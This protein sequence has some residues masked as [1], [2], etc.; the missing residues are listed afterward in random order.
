MFLASVACIFIVY[1]WFKVV[2]KLVGLYE[3]LVFVLISFE[4][5]VKQETKSAGV[6]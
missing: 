3:R 4:N 5:H 6:N 2:R 1:S